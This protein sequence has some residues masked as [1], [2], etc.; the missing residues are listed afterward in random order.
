VAL[1]GLLLAACTHSLIVVDPPGDLRPARTH[2]HPVGEYFDPSVTWIEGTAMFMSAGCAAHQFPY[3]VGSGMA[4][5]LKRIDRASFSRVASM[6]GP[7]QEIPGVR[8]AIIF[9][10]AVMR[11]T[12]RSE[13]ISLGTVRRAAEARLEIQLRLSIDG[14]SVPLDMVVGRGDVQELGSIFAGC[15]AIGDLIPIAISRSLEAA[16]ADYMTRIADPRQ[17]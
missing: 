17:F 15:G 13:R 4:D 3:S 7:T 14:F 2:D 12:F 6:T 10:R 1:L 11:V 16:A 5:V 8:R 9:E